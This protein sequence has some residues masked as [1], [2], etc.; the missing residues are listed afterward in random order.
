MSIQVEI[1]IPLYKVQFGFWEKSLKIPHSIHRL[2]KEIFYTVNE[3]A[4]GIYALAVNP[5]LGGIQW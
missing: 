5:Q 3:Q 2:S 1:V 4:V